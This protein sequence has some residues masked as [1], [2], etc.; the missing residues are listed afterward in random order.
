MVL[1]LGRCFSI[2]GATGHESEESGALDAAVGSSAE[3]KTLSEQS[4]QH[5]AIVTEREHI[6]GHTADDAK[7]ASTLQRCP[8]YLGRHLQLW[9]G[10]PT[11]KHLWT[12]MTG[13]ERKM[14]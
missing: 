8:G 13:E 4:P 5:E 11:I 6:S 2:G 10:D 7:V 3:G 9:V 12:A 14:K 1:L